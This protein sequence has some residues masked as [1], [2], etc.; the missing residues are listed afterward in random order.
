MSGSSAGFPLGQPWED[1]LANLVIITSP[2]YFVLDW[3]PS[4]FDF[5]CYIRTAMFECGGIAEDTPE[6]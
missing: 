2:T 5:G 1:C 3:D 4:P 6:L